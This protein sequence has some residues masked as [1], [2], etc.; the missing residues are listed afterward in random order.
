MK[1]KLAENLRGEMSASSVKVKCPTLNLNWI[2][3]TFI[4]QS[5]TVFI[6]TICCFK[7]TFIYLF[8]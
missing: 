4:D 2:L 8:I 6:S 3:N 1:T 5:N 7:K